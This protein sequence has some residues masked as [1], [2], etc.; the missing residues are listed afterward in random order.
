MCQ[1]HFVFACQ[2]TQLLM[3]HKTDQ[4]LCTAK[5]WIKEEI[6]VS[7]KSANVPLQGLLKH[8][9][10]GLLGVHLSR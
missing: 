10:L 3:N 2:F 8:R 1:N 5:H 6:Q 4:L 9:I 7:T